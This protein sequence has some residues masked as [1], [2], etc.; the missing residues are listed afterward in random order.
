[1][2]SVLVLVGAARAEAPTRI[3]Q[4]VELVGL[5]ARVEEWPE[6]TIAARDRARSQ[7]DAPAY[8]LLERLVALAYATAPLAQ[9]V[10]GALAAGAD[11]VRVEAFLAWHETPRGAR[12]RSGERYF[13]GPELLRTQPFFMSEVLSGK[14]DPTRWEAA[15]ELESAIALSRDVMAVALSI[16]I[17]VARGAHALRCG[18]DAAWPRAEQRTRASVGRLGALVEARVAGTIAFSHGDLSTADLI[19]AG[20]FARSGDARWLYDGVGVQLV[21]ALQGA[22][23]RLR[24]QLAPAVAERCP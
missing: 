11:P 22:S 3:A 9:T 2:A 8:A 16:S 24:M 23:R 21:D 17:G 4:A 7:L 6:I 12:L 18:S 13:L 15:R 10:S 1:M 5:A 19:R 20:R 14:L